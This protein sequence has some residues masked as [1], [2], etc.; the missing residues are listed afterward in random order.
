MKP[1]GE[2]MQAAHTVDA[3]EN[4]DVGEC[5]A[6]ILACLFRFLRRDVASKETGWKPALRSVLRH[7]LSLILNSR[8]TSSGEV[9]LTR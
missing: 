3:W 9:T 2:K 8:A 4:L 6:G 1:N 7:S 5:G